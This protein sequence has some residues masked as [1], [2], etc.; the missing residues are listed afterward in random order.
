MIQ[1]VVLAAGRSTRMG[2][3]KALL[4]LDGLP[5]LTRLLEA[6]KEAGLSNP[7]V[8][9]GDH[10]QDIRRAVPLGGCHVVINDDPDAGMS[11]SL[12]LGIE[13][14]STS[15]WGALLFLVDMP[16]MS[17]DSIRAVTNASTEGTRLA[18]AFYKT[19]RGFPVFFHRTTF[20]TLIESLHGDEGGRHYLQRHRHD[21]RKVPVQDP[22]CVYD[23]DRPEDID[24]WKGERECTING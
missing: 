7:I 20:R 4:N 10:A 3:N 6:L 13:S 24:A 21:V 18:A 8:V 23:I 1:P 15:A 11:R 17:A 5:A 12:R 16:F 22:G 19:K 14:V 2:A 9:L